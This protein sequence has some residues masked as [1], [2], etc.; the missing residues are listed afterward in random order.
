MELEEIKKEFPE[1]TKNSNRCIDMSG[2][3]IGRLTVLYRSVNNTNQGQAMWVCQCD[4]GKITIVRGSSLRNK[5]A[6]S[7]GCL[8]YE[9]ASK[10]NIKNLIGKRFGYLTVIKDTGKRANHRVVWLCQCDCGK[11]VERVSDSLS[12]GNTFSCGHCNQSIGNMLIEQILKDKEIK[13]ELEK[14]FNDLKGKNNVPFRY[15]F[16]LPEYNRLIEFDGFQHYS[17]TSIYYTETIKI[18]DGIK[19]NYALSNNIDLVRIP[20]WELKN[21]TI[22]MLLGDKYLVK[23]SKDG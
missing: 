11:Q 19:N 7:C 17:E 22:D 13:Y 20:Y 12:Q 21:L 6:T 16:Y 23:E 15:D 3:K 9:N 1:Y 2:Q 18:N 10:A 14:T 4:C 5:R 8:T